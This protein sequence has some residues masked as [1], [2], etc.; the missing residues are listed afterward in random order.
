MRGGGSSADGIRDGREEIDC[1]SIR[2]AYY[3]SWIRD[4][5]HN[6][7]SKPI[8]PKFRAMQVVMMKRRMDA[9]MHGCMDA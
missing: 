8:S 2:V 1:V 9:W 7:N 4:W 5:P 3:Y 6:N